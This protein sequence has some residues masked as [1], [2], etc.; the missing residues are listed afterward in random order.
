MNE[1]AASS[2]ELYGFLWPEPA[3]DQSLGIVSLRS[4]NVVA[5]AHASI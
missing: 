3:V 5:R 1:C 2:S 4:Q